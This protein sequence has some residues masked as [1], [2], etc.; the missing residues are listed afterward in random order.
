MIS[1][2]FIAIIFQKVSFDQLIIIGQLLYSVYR[3][4]ASQSI[5]VYADPDDLVSNPKLSQH[6]YKESE[7]ESTPILDT[8]QVQC[9]YV[10]TIVTIIVFRCF[11]NCL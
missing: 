8:G 3:K 6:Q 7:H 11:W 9:V 2:K 1:L 4:E 10:C 5:P